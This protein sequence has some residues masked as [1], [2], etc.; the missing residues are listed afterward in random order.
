ML[1]FGAKTI[2]TICL[3]SIHKCQTSSSRSSILLPI[4]SG[5]I[6]KK[7]QY[8]TALPPSLSQLTLTLA[9]LLAESEPTHLNV[10]NKRFSCTIENH[11]FITKY[12]RNNATSPDTTPSNKSW[13]RHGDSP[14]RQT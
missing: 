11:F 14:E 10:A 1:I 7:H 9:G 2:S 8:C 5:R 6:R 3:S 13:P 12:F 4:S